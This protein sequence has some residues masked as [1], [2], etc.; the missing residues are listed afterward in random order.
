LVPPRALSSTAR[1]GRWTG[2]IRPRWSAAP[3]RP[4]VGLFFFSR[5]PRCGAVATATRSRR[6]GGEGAP[7]R[8]AGSERP[9]VSAPPLG[10]AECCVGGNG[11]A[12]PCA[13]RGAGTTPPGGVAPRPRAPRACAVRVMNQVWFANYTAKETGRNTTSESSGAAGTLT[14]AGMDDGSGGRSD[15]THDDDGAEDGAAHRPW[16]APTD[17]A[18]GGGALTGATQGEAV[19]PPPPQPAEPP[20]GLS[21]RGG[22]RGRS[23]SRASAL[24]TC[25]STT[26]PCPSPPSPFSL[27]FPFRR[28]RPAERPQRA[29]H[30]AA[31][32]RP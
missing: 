13:R 24:G 11:G 6:R 19:P 26:R 16:G 8:A 14:S 20:K 31:R 5:A 9:G 17:E 23:P 12:R 25:P 30:R 7:I 21:T 28:P 27:I 18:G 32:G 2:G 22:G 1:A 10:H 3:T 4:A 29:P 15:A